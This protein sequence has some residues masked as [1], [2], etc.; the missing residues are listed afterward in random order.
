MKNIILTIF[1]TTFLGFNLFSQ[2][3]PTKESLTEN[4][5]VW[6]IKF[7]QQEEKTRTELNKQPKADF[8][9]NQD[10]TYKIRF[11]NIGKGTWRLE[12][13]YIMFW[14]EKTESKKTALVLLAKVTETKE[15]QLTLKLFSPTKHYDWS[16]KL[17]PFN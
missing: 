5:M 9:I 1:L 2:T 12:G 6:S 4:W 3:K 11:E 8:V 13:D 16:I 15:E 17:V 7:P 10:G 14:S